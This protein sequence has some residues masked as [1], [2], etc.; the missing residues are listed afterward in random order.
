LLA[1]PLRPDFVT[2]QLASLVSR[3]I[4]LPLDTFASWKLIDQV[5]LDILIF[6]DWQPFPDQQS[7]L[8]QTRRIAPV[9][10]CLYT[11]G[12][13]CVF[14]A[15]DYYILPGDVYGYYRQ[16]SF[17]TRPQSEWMLPYAEQVI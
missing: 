10:V 13:S 8:F 15:I 6:P 12:S 3:I 1:T 9:Q 16:S 7:L 2:K 4:N 5:H 11:R 17:D 14:D